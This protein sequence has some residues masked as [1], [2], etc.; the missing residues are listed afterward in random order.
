MTHPQQPEL[1]RSN[2]GETTQDAQE[3]RAQNRD[4]NTDQSDDNRPTPSANR[5]A[6]ERRR[7][8]ASTVR[9]ALED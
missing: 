3:L 4:T 2:K 1:H 7:G 8:E 6:D 9:G 5:T